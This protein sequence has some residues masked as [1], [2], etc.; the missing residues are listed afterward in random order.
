MVVIISKQKQLFWA[1]I[2]TKTYSSKRKI[3]IANNLY[4]LP[5]MYWR[6]QFTYRDLAENC[7]C[8]RYYEKFRVTLLWWYDQEK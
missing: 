2:T 3:K 4:Y 8:L 1:A 6:M 5:A 7:F